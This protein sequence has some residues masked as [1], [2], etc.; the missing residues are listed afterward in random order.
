MLVQGVDALQKGQ[1][2]GGELLLALGEVGVELFADSDVVVV[3]VEI[4]DVFAVDTSHYF[5]T[6]FAAL[7]AFGWQLPSVAQVVAHPD[8]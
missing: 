4:V 6:F 2:G 3:L 7:D 5:K 8:G 1:A